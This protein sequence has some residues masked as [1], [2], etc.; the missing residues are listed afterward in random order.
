MLKPYG[1]LRRI[2]EGTRQSRAKNKKRAYIFSD[3]SGHP[4]CFFSDRKK[5]EGWPQLLFHDNIQKAS[6]LSTTS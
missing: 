3:T 2:L 6:E 5:E 4:D 1:A